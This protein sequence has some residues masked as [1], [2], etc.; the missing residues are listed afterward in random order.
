M[1][2]KLDLSKRKVNKGTISLEEMDSFMSEMCEPVSA[3]R[4]K[5][6][7][8]KKDSSNARLSKSLDLKKEEIVVV[9]S[10]APD[11]FIPDEIKAEIDLDSIISAAPPEDYMVDKPEVE[12]DVVLVETK[13]PE[14]F[15]P[16]PVTVERKVIQYNSSIVP[17][18]YDPEKG[19][20]EKEEKF[21]YQVPEGFEP[22]NQLILEEE[23]EEPTQEVQE[24]TEEV[25]EEEP[26]SAIE[27]LADQMA[28]IAPSPKELQEITK[29]ALLENKVLQLEKSLSDTRR[30]VMEMTHGTM[31]SGMGNAGGGGE[32]WL[33][34]LDDVSV[35]NIQDGDALVWDATLQQF[36][37]GTAGGGVD[38]STINRTL[39]RLQ[40]KFISMDD[41]IQKFLSLDSKL[42]EL[43]QNTT[44]GGS[45]LT[46][47]PRSFIEEIADG[48]TTTFVVTQDARRNVYE[49]DGIP[50]PT[51][52]LP[53][54]DIIIFDISGLSDPSSFDV[55]QNG[56]VLQ[57]GY[58]RDNTPGSESITINTASVDSQYT[59]LYY[60][61]TTI[62]G[63]GWIIQITNN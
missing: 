42:L 26:K 63:L 55:F 1:M 52:Q 11:D 49:L 8:E 2:E 60:R 17:E 38:L 43:E 51:V 46:P 50:Q 48:D 10:L 32:V 16:E 19:I 45:E 21:V 35:N 22:K 40:E 20:E 61:H 7:K 31:V 44:E 34:Y 57:S 12:E 24:L 13:T 39:F 28:A 9:P 62:N 25:I 29:E 37:P 27:V 5:D 47:E 3:K 14:D 58:S 54:G 23:D 33:K 56:V 36:I 6:K 59:K 4:P 18:N 41:R 15:V 30:L 53:R